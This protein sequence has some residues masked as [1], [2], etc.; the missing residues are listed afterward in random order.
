MASESSRSGTGTTSADHTVSESP[1]V[2]PDARETTLP[3]AQVSAA[4]RHSPNARS[5]TAPPR[6]T[7]TTTSPAAPTSTPAT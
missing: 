6:P 7:P 3:M 2:A 5:G 4:S 1:P